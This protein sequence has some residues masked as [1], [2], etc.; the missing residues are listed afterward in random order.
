MSSL[1]EARKCLCASPQGTPVC[2]QSTRAHAGN[3][4]SSPR[5]TRLQQGW[6][7]KFKQPGAWPAPT[8][9]T[10]EELRLQ[11]VSLLSG[12][13]MLPA[14]LPLGLARHSS[15]IT[16]RTSP[17]GP[18]LAG[19][20]SSHMRGPE[21][22]PK[23][24][25]TWVVGENQ[26]KA[27]SLPPLSAPIPTELSRDSPPRPCQVGGARL[28]AQIKGG[29]PETEMCAPLGVSAGPGDVDPVG[30]LMLPSCL[31]V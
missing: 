15:L 4:G 29:C 17:Q 18:T 25:S 31:S 16:H 1:C 7:L 22:P 20:G 14:C 19:E 9:R 11:P 26:F 6:S 23:G 30:V 10:A 8:G 12:A 5:L 28:S 3:S 21:A 27:L 13:V 2:K 24:A